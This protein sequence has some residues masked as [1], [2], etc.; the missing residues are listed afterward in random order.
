MSRSLPTKNNP[1]LLA[2]AAPACTFHL[3]PRDRVSCPTTPQG[4]HRPYGASLTHPSLL[5]PITDEDLLASRRLGRTKL[6]IKP[7]LLG[8]C[9]GTKPENLGLF[10]YA[11]LRAPIPDDL[12]GSE[13]F[14]SRISTYFLMRR[15][16]DGSVSSS[17]MFK[18]AFPYATIE[19]HMNE[20]EYIRSQ[21]ST[22][23]DEVA[24]NVWIPPV[25][26]LE[27]AKEYKMYDWI[28]ALLD[29]VDIVQSARRYITPPPK[30]ELN[31][32]STIGADDNA[33]KTHEITT[34]MEATK[35]DPIPA[36]A[37]ANEGEE[38][39]L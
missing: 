2:E 13:I 24:G 14:P 15:S 28:R 23:Q 7:E 6:A 32:S 10:E 1:L 17:G 26:A 33:Q 25:F 21:E 18:V 11:H 20:R 3:A 12:E 27:L 22:S 8:T 30:F 37:D 29:P 39:P 19:E 31:T 36:K 16:K 35:I 38:S 9:S 4:A 5:I 34:L